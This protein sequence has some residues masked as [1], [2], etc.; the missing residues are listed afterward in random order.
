MSNETSVIDSADQGTITREE[1]ERWL[2]LQIS[3]GWRVR[4]PEAVELV[5]EAFRKG[6]KVA[7]FRKVSGSALTELL[8]WSWLAVLFFIGGRVWVRILFGL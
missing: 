4:N 6:A 7:P 5:R 3:M 8:F 1:F 2:A